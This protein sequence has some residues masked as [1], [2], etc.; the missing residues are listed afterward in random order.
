MDEPIT[1]LTPYEM[2]LFGRVASALSVFQII[3]FFVRESAPLP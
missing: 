3:L 2:T 1:A